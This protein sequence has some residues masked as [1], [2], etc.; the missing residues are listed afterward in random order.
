M[1]A[2]ALHKVDRPWKERRI[3]QN[4]DPRLR[5]EPDHRRRGRSNSS[6]TS[7]GALSNEFQLF[8]LR[9]RLFAATEPSRRVLGCS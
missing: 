9:R 2:D 6:N 8:E 3:T 7:E 4:R 1:L 5:G